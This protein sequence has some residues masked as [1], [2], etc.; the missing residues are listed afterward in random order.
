[1]TSRAWLLLAALATA[2]TASHSGVDGAPIELDGAV[3]PLD[4]P[5]DDCPPIGAPRCVD[6][7]CCAEEAP[8]IL[9]PGCD[10]VCPSGFIAEWE[11]EAGPTCADFASPCARHD[12]CTLAPDACCA[13]C[14]APTLGDVDPILES[15][16][17]DHRDFV[18]PDPGAFPCPRCPSAPAPNLIATCD[19]GRCAEHDVRQLPLSE[20]NADADC[21][22]R[23]RD[24]CEC[25]GAADFGSLIAV[26]ADSR[27]DYAALV[28][29]VDFGCPECEP[30]YPTDIEAYCETDGHCAVRFAP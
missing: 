9:R 7:A 27:N 17:G 14:G 18:C 5:R 26:R 2:C 11:C 16:A 12:E 19:T 28:C 20:C 22:L 1:M 30:V 25:G 4:A 23:T 21:V 29:E 6:T 8:A 24:C 3:P 15:R 13:P 10:Y